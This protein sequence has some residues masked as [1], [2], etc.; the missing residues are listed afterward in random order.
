MFGQAAMMHAGLWDDPAE[1]PKLEREMALLFLDIRNFT[2]LAGSFQASE[3]VH[4]IRKL[5]LTFQR[6]VRNYRGR[7]IETTGDGFYAAFGF[8]EEI[9]E[10]V[11]NAMDAGAA[12]L[13][14][15]ESM[16]ASSF[17]K[18]LGR[19]IEA[20]IGIH[21]GNVA[22]GSISLG[23]EQH[24]MVMGHAVNI[25]ARL[26]QATKEV[27]NN[28]LVSKHACEVAGTIDSPATMIRMKGIKT[29]LGVRLMGKKYAPT[30]IDNGVTTR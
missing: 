9:S 2:P 4:L 20:G 29:A 11:N 21:A 15:L 23:D 10:S 8:H 17:E 7:I 18:N 28:F 25:A 30:E 24:L 13:K 22:L 12:I 6:I 5:L 19:R 16:N 1:T 26:Q 14:S 3:V 27:N